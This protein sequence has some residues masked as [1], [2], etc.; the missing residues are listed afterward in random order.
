MAR[1]LIKSDASIKA[2]KPVIGKVTRLSDG[3]GLY[4]LIRPDGARWWRFDFSFEGKRKTLSLGV[5]PDTSLSLAR[6][7][8]DDARSLLAEGINPSDKRKSSKEEIQVQ[9]ENARRQAAGIAMVGSFEDY[10]MRWFAAY[11]KTV[12][13]RMAFNTKS[14]LKRDVLPA[15][16]SQPIE[17]VTRSDCLMVLRTIEA[18]GVSDTTRRALSAMRRVFIFADAEID[19]TANL[20]KSLAPAPRVKHHAA[21]TSADE[22]THLLRAID[23]YQGMFATQC[24]LKLSALFFVRPGELRRAEWSEIDLNAAEWSI[25]AEKMKMRVPHIVPLARQAVEILRD[26]HRVTGHGRYVFPAE[27]TAT[28]PMSDNTVRC[29]LRRLGYTNDEMTA[30][31]FRAMA[32]TILD[33]VLHERVD[34]IEH[35]LAHAVRDPLGRA[36]NRTTH[37]PERRAMMQRWADWLD[38][39]E[40]F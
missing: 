40:R 25:P 22:A 9:E 11:E 18:R 33:E 29:A 23:G 35:Q 13:P 6:K 7:K 10:A 37:L 17:K 15:I 31:G 2:Q 12:T 32:R 30:H 24:A 34:L 27:T 38:V 14:L 5:Y 4:L 8:A 1:H 28:R 21:I 36:Y 3:D 39:L 20:H 16:G 19:P 26:L